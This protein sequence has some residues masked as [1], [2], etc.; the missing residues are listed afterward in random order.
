MATTHFIVVCIVMG[1]LAIL[2]DLIK[3]NKDK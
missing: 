3:N 1:F 2:L